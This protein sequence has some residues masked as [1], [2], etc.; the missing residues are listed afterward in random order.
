MPF[1]RKMFL[2]QGWNLGH[3]HCSQNFLPAELPV[4]PPTDAM[5]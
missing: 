4:K 2:T 1:S 5:L 3:L